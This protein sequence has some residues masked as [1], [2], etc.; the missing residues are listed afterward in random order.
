LLELLELL[1]GELAVLVLLSRQ[2]LHLRVD[3][4]ALAAEFFDSHGVTSF[5]WA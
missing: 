5:S 1:G 2:G 4:G 3:L